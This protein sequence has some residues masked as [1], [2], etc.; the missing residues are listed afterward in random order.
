M[1]RK[2]QTQGQLEPQRPSQ[3]AGQAQPQPPAQ[4]E[5]QPPAQAQVQQA[6]PPKRAIC[7][8]GGGPAAG[9]HIGALEYLKGKKD[10]Y[11]HDIEF[12]VWALSCIGAWVG[13]IYNQAKKGE[14]LQAVRSFFEGVYREDKSFESFPTNTIF[15]PD[16]AGVAEAMLDFMFEPRNYQNALR[17]KQIRDSF[18]YTLRG[19]SR[20]ET[21]ERLSEGDFNRWTLNHLLAVHPVVRF[22]TAMIYKSQMSGLARLHYPGGSKFLNQIDFSNLYEKPH[23]KSDQNTVPYILYN[24]WNLSNKRLQLFTNK[25]PPG[26]TYGYKDIS[27]A[28]LCACSALPYIE[29]TVTIDGETYCEG[30]LRDTVN[31]QMLLEDHNRQGDPLDE[32]WIHRIL[33]AQQVRKPDNLCDALAN[34]CEMFAATVGEDDVRL[35]KHHIKQPGAFAGTIVE[36]KVD[37]KINFQWSHQNLTDGR[38]SGRTMA[39]AAYRL[40]SAYHAAK[41]Q[42]GQILMI[43]DDLKEQEIRNCLQGFTEQQISA[44]LAGHPAVRGN[45]AREN[46]ITADLGQPWRH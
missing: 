15:A 10:P 16:W 17:P 20:R 40:Y 39:D 14:E 8:A 4:A 21:W 22:W 18:L 9:L 42:P 26:S 45:R 25:T 43:P 38:T 23:G 29:E 12:G 11:G 35:F 30:A 28:S 31:F 6:R 33:D 24:A 46:K 41:K 34:L 36:I 19:V 3:P 37:S 13:V 32:I 1:T 7:L 44:V 27:P 5:P 2:P